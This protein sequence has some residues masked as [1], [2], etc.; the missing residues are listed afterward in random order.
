M[1]TLGYF[2]AFIAGLLIIA[3]AKVKTPL[4]NP[5]HPHEWLNVQSTEFHANKVTLIGDVTCQSCHG[6][7]L[8]QNNSFCNQCHSKQTEPIS[9]PHPPEWLS[10]NSKKNHGNFIEAHSDH[11]TCNRCHGGVNDLAPACSNCHVGK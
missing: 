6:T 8:G 5:T 2:F 7:N 3:C 10:F 9:Y 4:E 1:K 11:L